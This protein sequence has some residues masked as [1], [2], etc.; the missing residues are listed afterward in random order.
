MKKP[1]L[2]KENVEALFESKYIKTYDLT[3]ENMHYYNATRRNKLDQVAMKSDEEFKTM[4]PDAVSCVVIVETN[5]GYKLLLQYEF[6]YPCGQYLLSV[7]AGLIDPK[8]LDKPDPIVETAIR[9]IKE[10]T[11]ITIT[12]SNVKKISPVLF[13]TPGMSDESNALVEIMIKQEDLKQLSN[14]ESEDTEMFAGFE[15]LSKEDAIKIVKDETRDKYGNYMSMF[16]LG[17]ILY[18]ITEL[19]K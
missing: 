7:P 13:S 19:W 9:E 5:E 3:Y 4:M 8:D 14:D 17:G 15:L 12:A 16:T 10:E 18:F 1:L 2:I 11:G 6:R